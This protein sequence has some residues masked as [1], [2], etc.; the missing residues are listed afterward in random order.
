MLTRKKCPFYGHFCAQ[1]G[2]LRYGAR[3]NWEADVLPLNYARKSLISLG[4]CFLV[5]FVSLFLVS[6]FRL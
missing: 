6:P 4:I 3:T 1:R 2:G 5:S